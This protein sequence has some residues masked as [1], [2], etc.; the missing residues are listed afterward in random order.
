[1][2]TTPVND[3]QVPQATAAENALLGAIV[4]EPSLLADVRRTLPAAAW[5]QER[6][7]WAYEAMLA[8]LDEGRAIDPVTVAAEVARAHPKGT[9]IGSMLVS[10]MAAVPSV[11]YAPDWV[12]EITE[13]WQKRRLL[14]F[15][16]ETARDVA[17]ESASVVQQRAFERLLEMRAP[18][19][20]GP[21]ETGTLVGEMAHEI[22]WVL[23]NP[24]VVT[25]VPTPWARWTRATL[26]FEPG[27]LYFLAS[28]PGRGKSRLLAECHFAAARHGGFPVL[29]SLEM[30]AR[31]VLWRRA[32]VVAGVDVIAHRAGRRDM[33]E[34]Q[35]EALQR[36]FQRIAGAPGAIDDRSGLTVADLRAEV[37][38]LQVEQA[39][40]LVTVDYLG[41][42]EHP[43]ADDAVTRAREI[44]RSLKVLA[45]DLEVPVLAAVQLNRDAEKNEAPKLSDVFYGGDQDADQ[46]WA[47][48]SR[49]VDEAT[50]VTS[51]KRSI[52]G[53]QDQEPGVLQLRPLKARNVPAVGELLLHDESGTGRIV[54][55]AD[56]FY[57]TVR[58]HRLEPREAKR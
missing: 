44:A 12:A 25:G 10:A 14:S 11:L 39:V 20:R 27:R 22:Q 18:D 56:D 32:G 16:A 48:L 9:G 2:T 43:R 38:R 21:R 5:W 54:E 13:A 7:R 31:E 58:K 3:T 41:L 6:Y 45:R 23:D 29:F 42:L 40:S 8:L 49:D 53:V 24:G 1:V 34:Y 17:R 47:L 33:D 26:G 52:L 46:V 37:T 4:L 50:G 30:S 19:S 28:R 36:A 57:E 15:A 51:G 35:R 55:F